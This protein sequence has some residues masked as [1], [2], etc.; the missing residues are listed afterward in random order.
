MIFSLISF[1]G[2]E[3]LAAEEFG[4]PPLQMSNLLRYCK[5]KGEEVQAGIRPLGKCL[6]LAQECDVLWPKNCP[7]QVQNFREEFGY[8]TLS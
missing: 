1:G 4:P 7:H 2:A 3:E 8:V 5:A 6:I